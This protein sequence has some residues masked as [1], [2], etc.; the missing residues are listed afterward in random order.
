MYYV[1]LDIG[2]LECC[3]VSRV[4]GIFTDKKKAHEVCEEHRKR[5]ILTR[6]KPFGH[7]KFKVVFIRELET[8]YRVNYGQQ[9]EEE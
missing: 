4:I 7:H 6:K 5:Q 2:C 9:N 1:A 3:E 8:E